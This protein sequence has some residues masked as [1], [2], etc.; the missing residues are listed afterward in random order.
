MIKKILIALFI[1][2][3]MPVFFAQ[4]YGWTTQ[5]CK[6]SGCGCIGTSEEGKCVLTGGCSGCKTPICKTR[7]SAVG[8]TCYLF[9]QG[10][11]NEVYEVYKDCDSS[12]KNLLDQFASECR[13]DVAGKG[14]YYKIPIGQCC[15]NP[16][17]IQKISGKA[18]NLKGEGLP[19]VPILI[20]CDNAQLSQ[21][22]FVS[23]SFGNFVISMQAEK[24]KAVFCKMIIGSEKHIRV[25]LINVKPGDI[26]EIKIAT[27]AE[28]E[29]N[30]KLSIMQMLMDSGVTREDAVASVAY[31]NFKYS[32]GSPSFQE[33]TPS[34]ITGK[35]YGQNYE[36]SMDPQQY[37]T[38][39][40]TLYHEMTHAIVQKMF[41]D[42]VP[43]SPSHDIYEKLSET[44]A[45]DEGRAHFFA[46]LMLKKTGEY[47]AAKDQFQDDKVIKA[48]TNKI[49]V[50]GGEGSSVE[51]SVTTFLKDYY[52]NIKPEDA[53]KDYVKTL[54]GCKEKLGHTCQTIN[55]FIKQKGFIGN[56]LYQDAAKLG[57]KVDIN[58]TCIIKK[59]SSYKLIDS[60]TI[61]LDS[62][63]MGCGARDIRVN[64][65]QINR[66]GTQ[67]LVAKIGDNLNISVLEG[68]VKATNVNNNE[69]V[70]IAV[71]NKITYN[72]SAAEFSSPEKIDTKNI[73]K[74]WES[75]AQKKTSTNFFY[76]VVAIAFVLGGIGVVLFA[77]KFTRKSA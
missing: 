13:N 10:E 6:N 26:G 66:G 18:V 51:A 29:T 8:T 62:G 52:V 27:V 42:V 76:P 30:M 12:C 28:Y 15:G 44:G 37:L 35:M 70:E 71:G 49:N 43:P 60:D 36:I 17:I 53:W 57:I 20:K 5:E 67:Y 64:D 56:G 74:F 46:Y 41:P 11:C 23:D 4:A 69:A 33:V 47:D 38:D 40:E 32:E 3:L 48:I 34:F 50:K 14:D 65:I 73:E 21:T 45:F 59:D 19:Y 24:D 72:A 16:P 54:N 7:P 61:Q 1:V 58:D 68:S 39:R 22:K 75:D 31:I 55:E 2:S 25:T 77:R 63:E 9:D